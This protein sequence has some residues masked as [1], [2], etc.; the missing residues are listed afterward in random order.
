MSIQVTVR[1][2]LDRDCQTTITRLDPPIRGTDAHTGRESIVYAW[3]VE[4]DFHEARELTRT[5][6]QAEREA[7]RP[8]AWCQECRDERPEVRDD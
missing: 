4:C 1:R 7:R 8:G 6:R 2:G 3:R 5:R